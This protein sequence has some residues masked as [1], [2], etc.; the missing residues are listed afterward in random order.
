M[1]QIAQSFSLELA[2]SWDKLPEPVRRYLRYAIST[3]APTIR[4]ARLK[5]DGFFRT[6]P[7]QNWL[8]IKGEEYFTIAKPGFVW[9]ASV[10]LAPL[11]WIQARDL[12]QAGQAS[13]LVKVNSLHHHR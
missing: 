11:L 8:A 12:M 7:N 5:H 6:K 10:R 4:T 2:A 13:M 3:E 9:D 1:V